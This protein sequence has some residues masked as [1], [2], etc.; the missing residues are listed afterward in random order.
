MEFKNWLEKDLEDAVDEMS[1]WPEWMKSIVKCQQLE[2][3]EHAKNT[4]NL[5][6]GTKNE[7]VM[8]MDFNKIAAAANKAAQMKSF[9]EH[10]TK[11]SS[12]EIVTRS[13]S[14][15]YMQFGS[16]S[17]GG[18]GNILKEDIIKYLENEIAKNLTIINSEVSKP[19]VVRTND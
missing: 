6:S 3:S 11:A 7:V 13:P 14:Q 2:L 5:V 8:N 10:L 16:N 1:R 4:S 9:I 15:H 18:D 17:T 12:F 19:L